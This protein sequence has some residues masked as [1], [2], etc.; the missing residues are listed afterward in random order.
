MAQFLKEYGFIL[1]IFAILAVV[2]IGFVAI[3]R[4]SLTDEHSNF[5]IAASLA[6]QI[7]LPVLPPEASQMGLVQENSPDYLFKIKTILNGS[8]IE[9]NNL[10]GGQYEKIINNRFLNN[11]KYEN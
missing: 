6:S 11:Q 7:K 9:I 2:L 4:I 5:K 3:I 10:I 1:I 8:Q